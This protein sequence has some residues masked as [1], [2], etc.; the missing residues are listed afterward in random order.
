MIVD[1]LYCSSLWSSGSDCQAGLDFSASRVKPDGF[2]GRT[3][4]CLS[5]W[6]APK[7]PVGFDGLWVALYS[8]AAAT[9][10]ATFTVWI[11][12]IWTQPH[13]DTLLL[14]MK[15]KSQHF[16]QMH[17]NLLRKSNVDALPPFSL[18]SAPLFHLSINHFHSS[19]KETKMRTLC[20]RFHRFISGCSKFSSWVVT[21]KA[22]PTTNCGTNWKPRSTCIATRL[23]FERVEAATMPRGLFL[24]L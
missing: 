21:W 4:G 17:V 20:K 23:S 24:L 8:V 10:E 15:Y 7:T 3:D 12:S 2:C 13:T 9:G 18:H 14:E 6:T 19:K 11:S 22:P 5:V 1:S 16:I